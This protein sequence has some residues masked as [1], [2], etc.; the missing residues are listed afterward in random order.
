MGLN[1]RHMTQAVRDM[2]RRLESEGALFN[3]QPW[4]AG[5]GRGVLMISNADGLAYC[6]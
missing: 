1:A 4:G 3:L 2:Y 5:Q 6:T